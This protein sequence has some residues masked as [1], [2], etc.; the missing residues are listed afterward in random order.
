MPEN[1]QDFF[2]RKMLRLTVILNDAERKLIRHKKM[3]T[4]VDDEL[5]SS[6]RELKRVINLNSNVTELEREQS[7]ICIVPDMYKIQEYMST[8]DVLDFLGIKRAT[9]WRYEK[10]GDGPPIHRV[11]NQ[12]LYTRTEIINWWKSKRHKHKV[13][14]W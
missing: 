10:R 1:Q 6:F 9:L 2:T 3:R 11:G 8:L 4:P 13:R 12:K 14:R 7:V 5:L